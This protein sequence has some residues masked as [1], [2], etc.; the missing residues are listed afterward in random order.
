V[1][2]DRAVQ[3]FDSVPRYRFRIRHGG[4]IRASKR[5]AIGRVLAHKG[6]SM[7]KAQRAERVLGVE[8]GG[9]KTAWVL[10]ERD[11]A[12]DLRVVEEGKL[13]PS[14][15][16]LTPSDRLRSIFQ[17]LPRE[18]DRVGMFLAGCGVE[19]DRRAL[20]KLCAGIWP[21]AKII[22]GSD[23]D[24]GL[25]AA[26]G[27]GDGIAVNAGSGA[28]VTGRRGDRIEQAGGW[29]HILGDTGGGYSLSLQALRLILR[30][31][32]LHRGEAQF[33]ASILRALSLNSRDELVR[34]AQTADKMEIAMLCPVV[35]EA[36]RNGDQNVVKIIEEGAEALAEY[37]AAVE[38][39]LGLL[40]PKVIL[41]GG[42]FQRDSLYVAAFR[43]KL[44]KNLSDACVSI[45]ERSP[46]LGA[47]WLA[48]DLEERGTFSFETSTS[49]LETLASAQTEQR[50]SRS[51]RLESLTAQELVELFVDEEGFVQ[52]A[53]R[54]E[55][56]ALARGIEIVATALRKS[57]RLFYVGA[58]TSGRLG[59]LDA[60]ELP[61][62]FG[63]SPEL[64]QGI[65][66]G[67]ARSL[68]RSAEGAEDEPGGGALAIDERG[69]TGADVICGI[70][71]SGRTPFVLGALVAAKKRG[72]QTI[73]LT[74][75][76]DRIRTE[77]FA[78]EIDF[79]TGPEIL[80]GSTRL[81][82]GTATKIALNILSTGAMVALGRVRGN[83]MIDL[84]TASV[85]LRDRA[86]RLVAECAKCDYAEARD[87]L[88]KNGWNLRAALA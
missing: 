25:A 55:I 64:V 21:G 46:E 75:N 63:V 29:G 7:A 26:L 44:K 35:F 69:V 50:N 10:V 76:L 43:R 22:A 79:A 17:Q 4:I 32:D 52:E 84:S 20:E 34:W 53:L 38:T 39:R 11:A 27:H 72:A 70:S 9:T 59:V 83:L 67:G 2:F 71:A 45:S 3:F 82:A 68:F 54:K 16:R 57:G 81:K 48:A 49:G 41:L 23:R 58:G 60:S 74:C 14:N 5:L 36:A 65:I 61:P 31:Y 78:L 80:T 86:T 33:T 73:L 28:T 6:I 47:A 66:A 87:R 42:L 12:A 18:V 77:P 1:L 37:T 40:A 30:E 51:E 15:F 13:P 85:K 19:E 56:P 24:S 88:Q 62:T 8:G